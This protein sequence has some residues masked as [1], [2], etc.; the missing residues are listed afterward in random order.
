MNKIFTKIATACAGLAM[1][2]GVGVAIGNN[3]NVVPAS[4]TTQSESFDYSAIK[5]NGMLSGDYTDASSY[6]KVPSEAG[7]T[8]TITINLGSSFTPT[9]NIVMTFKIATFGSGTNPSSTNTTVTTKGYSDSTATDWTANSALSSYPTSSTYVNATQTVTKP[10][11]PVAINKIVTT[12]SLNSGVKIFRLQQVTY[13]F[14]YSGGTASTKYT[15]TYDK[16]GAT[17]GTVPTD[18][19]NYEK[20]A[21]VTVLGNT[22]NLAKTDFEFAGW[23]TAKDG[24]GTTYVAGD[25]FGIGDNT[26]LYAKW[27]FDGPE[28]AK[29]TDLNV[30]DKVAITAVKSGVNYI[31]PSATNTNSSPAA[32]VATISNNK[33]QGVATTDLFTVEKQDNTHFA[34][35]NADNKYLYIS[36]SGNS[37][38]RVGSTTAVY[39]TV[40]ATT[41]GFKMTSGNTGRWL[42]VYETTDWRSYNS[43]TA[44]NYGGSAEAINFYGIEKAV[45]PLDT[46]EL[47]NAPTSDMEIGDKVNLGYYGMDTDAEDWTGNVTYTSSNTNVATI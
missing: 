16:N 43:S 36:G 11:N 47:R 30:A 8:A 38:V 4:A 20:N 6:W 7:K 40:T 2:I 12:F 18:E 22:G 45:A 39:W 13:S 14:D 9:T 5:T 41:N 34:F 15:V 17:S 26:T 29:I 35:K 19:T 27:T 31:V 33:L 3:A 1:A 46:I 21:T 28:F 44:S 23:N 37:N 32:T 10:Q 25:T 42:G 24:S